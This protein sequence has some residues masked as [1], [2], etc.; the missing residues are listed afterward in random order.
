[1]IPGVDYFAT[2]KHSE[3]WAPDGRTALMTFWRRPL[4]AMTD[5]FTAADFRINVI[6]EPFP[7]PGARELS[8]ISSWTS[9]RG[10]FVC[11]LFFVVQA[12]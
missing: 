1:M 4:H 5:A 6:S 11:F 8:P 7:A 9:R 12:D 2:H 3:E 10:A